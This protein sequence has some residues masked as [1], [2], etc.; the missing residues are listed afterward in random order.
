[1]EYHIFLLIFNILLFSLIKLLKIH[2]TKFALLNYLL[3]IKQEKNTNFLMHKHILIKVVCI[4][5]E[6][7]NFN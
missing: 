1:M 5:T 3:N 4:N 2:A 7:T 6:I